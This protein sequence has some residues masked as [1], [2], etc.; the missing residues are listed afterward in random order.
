L[1]IRGTIKHTPSDHSWHNLPSKPKSNGG[2][3]MKIPPINTVIVDDHVLFRQGLIKLFESHPEVVIVGQLNSGDG[4]PELLADH[5][6]D[7]VILDISLPGVNGLELINLIKKHSPQT[8]TLILSM[9]RIADYCKLAL[10]RGAKAF[11]LKADTFEDLNQ[12]IDTI[13]TSE[14]VYISPGISQA[15]AEQFFMN[16]NDILPDILTKTEK[17]ILEKIASGLS[18]KEIGEAMKIS[19][20]TVET[21]RAHILKKL[22]IKN[23]AGLVQYAVKQNIIQI[24]KA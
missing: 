8:K 1:N 15:A 20:R 3:T 7:L 10:K 6:V 23:T 22:K 11:V 4:L 18:N 12:A 21:H 17:I 16:S 14:D 19:V 2:K 24:N 5:S 9:H 13:F